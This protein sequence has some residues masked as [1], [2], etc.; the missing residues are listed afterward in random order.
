MTRPT[1]VI[2][3]AAARPTSAS[4]SS[5]IRRRSA[6]DRPGFTASTASATFSCAV[7]Q[8]SSA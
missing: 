7:I 5:V 6:A 1:A 3:E 4:S 2:A 8:G